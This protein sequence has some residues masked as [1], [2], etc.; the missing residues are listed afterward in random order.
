MGLSSCFAK[1]GTVKLTDL[2][3]LKAGVA[4]PLLVRTRSAKPSTNAVKSAPSVAEG[5]LRREPTSQS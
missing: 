4:V 3:L 5:G 2:M 1:P